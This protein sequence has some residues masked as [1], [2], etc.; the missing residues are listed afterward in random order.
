MYE[1]ERKLS[2]AQSLAAAARTASAN[3]VGVDL[4]GYEAAMIVVTTGTITDGTHA[5]SLEESADNTTWNAVAASDRI[6][7]LPTITATDDNKEF[8]FSYI[9]SKRYIRVVTTVSGATSG[10]VYAALVIRGAARHEPAA[11]AQVP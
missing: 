8:E 1:I 5:I 9:G 4:A 3:G 2:V 6:G 7:A 11:A 10:G